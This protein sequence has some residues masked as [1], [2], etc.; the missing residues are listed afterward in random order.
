MEYLGKNLLRPNYLQSYEGSTTPGTVLS[1]NWKSSEGLIRVTG[2]Q[3]AYLPGA[4]SVIGRRRTSAPLKNASVNS[5]FDALGEVV[6]YLEPNWYPPSWL[7]VQIIIA[8]AEIPPK[9]S[10]PTRISATPTRPSH[11]DSL[12]TFDSIS[13]CAAESHVT[14]GEAVSP[15]FEGPARFSILRRRHHRLT[16]HRPQPRSKT[17]APNS[18]NIPKMISLTCQGMSPAADEATAASSVHAIHAKRAMIQR[19][20]GD[21]QA[22]SK[23]EYIVDMP[24]TNSSKS[25][26]KNA[27]DNSFISMKRGG[28]L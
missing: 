4:T 13:A 1:S 6:T 17:T 19:P 27:G 16:P 10:S 22:A 21:D 28:T 25:M 18:E 15:R 20:R 3:A 11:R 5:W 26:K 9:V 12:S 24:P 2:P 7:T 23:R 8:V 14:T